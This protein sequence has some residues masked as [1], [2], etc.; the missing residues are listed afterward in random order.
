MNEFCLLVLSLGSVRG[1][2][3]FAREDPEDPRR[4]IAGGMVAELGLRSRPYLSLNAVFKATCLLCIWAS[5]FASETHFFSCK[6]GVTTMH[7][8]LW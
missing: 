4:R 1:R 3:R 8:E 5:N 7:P 6:V 2:G